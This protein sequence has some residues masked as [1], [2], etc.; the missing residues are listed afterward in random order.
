METIQSLPLVLT[1][2]FNLGLFIFHLFFWRLFRWKEQLQ[3]VSRLNS[4]VMQVMNLC[5][6]ALF[7]FAAYLSFFHGE[8]LVTTALGN[9]VLAGFA[10]FWFLRALE[11][12]VFFKLR[13]A[14]SVAFTLFFFLGG[15]LYAFPLFA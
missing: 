2:F 15:A 9:A 8:E 11:Q 14:I 3:K 13:T 6:M 10:L 7:L 12:A 4:N 5:L 1:G